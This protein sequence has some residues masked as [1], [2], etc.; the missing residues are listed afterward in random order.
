V[1]PLG[2]AV[3]SAGNLYIADR[4]NNR[5]RKVS[6]GVIATVA[7]NGTLGFSGDNGPATSAQL[8]FPT[9]VAVDS[10]GSLYIAD[11][12]NN[13][14]RKVSN[15]LITTVAGNG[16]SGFS[17]DNGP[18]TSA[19]LSQPPG[20]AVDFVGNLYIADYFNNRIRKISNGVITTV[21]GNGMQGFGGDNGPAISAQ[22]NGPN[23][24]AVN[25]AGN[26][27]IADEFNN[28]IRLLTPSGPS[29]SASVSPTTLSPPISG[30]NQ[31]VTIQ[32]SASCAWALQSLPSWI[33]YSGNVVG[34]GPATITLAVAPNS[35]AGRTADISIAGVSVSVTQPGLAPAIYVGG[36]VNAASDAAGTPLAPGS[37]ATAYGNFLLT[38]PFSATSS[39]LPTNLGGS[40]CSSPPELRRPCFSPTPGR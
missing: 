27:Y 2:V 17:G 16:T 15:G 24:V 22:L 34:A 35:G 6:N 31:S 30:G 8:N 7:G 20:V 13:R 11:S 5:I 4:A 26:V 37:I 40:P 9:G 39:P 1:Y 36:I 32:T 25:A 21:A 3:D 19:Q 10:A 23:G 18:A 12:I 38:A 33:T 14:I 28:R 29:C